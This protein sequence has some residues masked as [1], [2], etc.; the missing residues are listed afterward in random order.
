MAD[1][2]KAMREVGQTADDIQAPDPVDSHSIPAKHATSKSRSPS[3]LSSK[4][5]SVKDD[6]GHPSATSRA[7]SALPG[8][9]ELVAQQAAIFKGEGASEALKY[10]YLQDVIQHRVRLL[11]EYLRLRE[12]AERPWQL[13]GQDEDYH[14]NEWQTLSSSLQGYS[15]AVKRW[16]TFKHETHGHVGIEPE[17][18][19]DVNQLAARWHVADYYDQI[20]RGPKPNPASTRETLRLENITIAQQLRTELRFEAHL[21][22][23]P[24]LV[25]A[26]QDAEV[27]KEEKRKQQEE[28]QREKYEKFWARFWMALF[29]GASLVVP[30]I[31]MTLH[32]TRTT[33][34]ATTS[35]FTFFVAIL[36][37]WFMSTADPKDVIA[38]IAAYAAVLVVFVGTSQQAPSSGNHNGHEGGSKSSLSGGAI[39]GIVVGSLAG[40]FLLLVVLALCCFRGLVHGLLAI[41]GLRKRRQRR[42]DEIGMAYDNSSYGSYR[43][44]RSSHISTHSATGQQD[45]QPPGSPEVNAQATS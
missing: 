34:L 33:T 11:R 27:I 10:L 16:T 31:I 9:N 30:M 1:N 14:D 7:A 23:P 26:D 12:E 3:S 45:P 38:A 4:D 2:E 18:A 25:Q 21:T 35:V 43:S 5:T 32:S 44:S 39:A 42:A 13:I 24:T 37:A 41:F 8:F 29:G 28:R 36:L 15:D 17:I 22:D 40:C 20:Y 19:R 6:E